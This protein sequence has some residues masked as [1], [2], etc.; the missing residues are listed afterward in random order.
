MIQ[1]RDASGA[2]DQLGEVRPLAEVAQGGRRGQ[3]PPR[4]PIWWFGGKGNQ[5]KRLLPLLPVN[6]VDCYV[7]PFGGA[8]TVML[9]RK[10]AQNEVYNDLNSDLVNMWRVLQDAALGTELQ[11]RL[12]VTPYAREEFVRALGVLRGVAP[13][14]VSVDRAW[15]FIVAQ[16]QGFSGKSGSLG[17][18]GTNKSKSG[19]R[20]QIFY[21]SVKFLHYFIARARRW[22][23]EHQ[24][25]LRVI[26]RFDSPNTLFYCDPPYVHSTRKGSKDYRHEMNDDDHRE[27]VK[28]LLGVQ[29]GVALSGYD[30]ELYG[31]LVDAG[32]TAERW[33]VAVH[34]QK[35]VSENRPT[36]IELL[37][38]NPRCMEMMDAPAVAHPSG[39]RHQSRILT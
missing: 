32:W 6:G 2:L 21:N 11:R 36:R 19:T 22:Y 9:W 18:W 28:A 26:R 30:S 24:P 15:A 16:R 1:N 35:V 27:L 38:R 37:W 34:S 25:A 33:V 14:G 4:S 10:P 17:D 39:C 13:D 20:P 8:G 31:P 5:L 12:Q 29:G 3:A 7:E 23:V